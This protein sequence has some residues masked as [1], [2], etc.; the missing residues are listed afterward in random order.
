M[1]SLPFKSSPFGRASLVCAFFNI[2]A[3]AAV[4]IVY[5]AR[6][7][8][9]KNLSFGTL[10]LIYVLGFFGF[11]IVIFVISFVGTILSVGSLYTREERP[12]LAVLGLILNGGPFLVVVLLRTLP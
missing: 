4:F 8:F 3:F 11:V 2:L 9:L 6:E 12:A 7:F 10:Q 5:L 1:K